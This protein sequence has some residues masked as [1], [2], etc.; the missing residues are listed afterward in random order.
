MAGNP[1]LIYPLDLVPGDLFT[2]R[3]DGISQVV[4]FMYRKGVSFNSE[5]IFWRNDDGIIQSRVYS[6]FEQLTLV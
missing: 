3:I 5:R 4:T 2:V 1:P 6:I